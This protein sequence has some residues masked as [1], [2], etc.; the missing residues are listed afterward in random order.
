M[1]SFL[2]GVPN[3]TH[4]L[5]FSYLLPETIQ[6]KGKGSAPIGCDLPEFSLPQ[7]DST[8]L[9]KLCL[10]ELKYL[11]ICI[12]SYIYLSYLSFLCIYLCIYVSMYVSIYLW[13]VIY[14]PFSRA[15]PGLWPE[16]RRGLLSILIFPMAFRYCKI[17]SIVAN[18]NANILRA[19]LNAGY[20][21]L[22]H[23]RLTK[24]LRSKNS[25]CFIV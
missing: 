20:H 14:M 8:S 25:Y 19:F 18:D 23:R 5:S 12:Y 6:I 24:T 17:C 21:A 11:Y 9:P 22:S 7:F 16:G 3:P 13:L 10:F 2:S 1:F 15:S 4:H